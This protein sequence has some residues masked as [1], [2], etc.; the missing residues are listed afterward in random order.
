MTIGAAVDLAGDHRSTT[1][2]PL[3]MLDFVPFACPSYVLDATISK[4]ALRVIV[5]YTVCIA[6]NRKF[7]SY[8]W[9]KFRFHNMNVTNS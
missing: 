5:W 8:T 3:E 9:L 2:K 7:S 4:R 1:G 6:A